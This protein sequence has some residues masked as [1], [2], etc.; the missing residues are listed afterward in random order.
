MH[1]GFYTESPKLRPRDR[2][3]FEATTPL[4]QEAKDVP[5]RSCFRSAGEGGG[6]V[7]GGVGGTDQGPLVQ[8]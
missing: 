1:W 7:G 4:S 6:G 5:E 8:G 2:R 3:H